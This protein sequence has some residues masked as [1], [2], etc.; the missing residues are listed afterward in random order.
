MYLTLWENAP[1]KLDFKRGAFRKMSSYKTIIIS[2]FSSH[3]L[4]PSNILT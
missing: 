2:Q 3:F 1:I 4:L